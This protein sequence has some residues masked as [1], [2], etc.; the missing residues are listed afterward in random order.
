MPSERVVVLRPQLGAAD[1][2]HANLRAGFGLSQD[3][4][5]ELLRV[6][7]SAGGTHGV[8]KLLV[9]RRW[10]HADAPRW[11]LEVLFFN[12]RDNIR[13]RESESGEPVRPQPNAHAVV[14]TAEEIDLGN[15]WDAQDLIAQVDTGIIDQK[16]GVV[17]S[18]RRIERDE[19][20][21]ARALL[22]DRDS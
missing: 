11:G 13:R 20:E 2:L 22:L 9:L 16:V 15:A 3:D 1:V 7:Q 12:R 8:G 21:D 17:A 4:V 14:S 18:L 19:H 6:N 10:G 5:L